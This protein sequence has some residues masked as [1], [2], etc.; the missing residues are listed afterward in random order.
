MTCSPELQIR[1]HAIRVRVAVSWLAIAQSRPA[2]A[3]LACTSLPLK[4]QTPLSMVNFALLIVIALIYGERAIPPL[5]TFI[6]AHALH[7]CNTV[8]RVS[9]T[10][11]TN[12]MCCIVKH[13][14]G[15]PGNDR[16]DP[17]HVQWPANRVPRETQTRVKP[18]E[19][20][21]ARRLR[22]KN[23]KASTSRELSIWYT[24]KKQWVPFR[25]FPATHGFR[26]FRLNMPCT[27]T[28]STKIVPT[29]LG[30]H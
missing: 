19:L 6:I 18:P 1:L 25:F 28:Q 27:G 22:R 3:G 2:I 23:L 16:L 12:G 11:M 8:R 14:R 26:G 10:Q 7:P 9:C 4:V 20:Q 13:G 29:S 30:F 24:I 5:H 17:A 15:T 21:G